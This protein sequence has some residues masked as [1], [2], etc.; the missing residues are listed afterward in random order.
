[1]VFI[2]FI[3]YFNY[4]IKLYIIYELVIYY[5]KKNII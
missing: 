3:Q 2:E 4:K 5:Y 1:M